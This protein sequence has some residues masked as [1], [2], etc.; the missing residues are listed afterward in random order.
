MKQNQVNYRQGSN[1]KFMTTRK[2]ISPVKQQGEMHSNCV[3]I[4]T[5]MNI[6]SETPSLQLALYLRAN[7][8]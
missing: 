7:K 1:L 6:Y 2:K 8:Y 3:L 5:V 4:R